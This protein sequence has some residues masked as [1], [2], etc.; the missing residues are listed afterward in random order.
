MGKKKVLL[1]LD[2]LG[3]LPSKQL[4]GKTP[5]EAAKTPNLDYLAMNSRHGYMY[6]L[7]PGISPESD[8]ATLA[9]LGYNPL[10]VYTGR[11]PLEAYGTGM[12]LGRNFLALRANFAT[13]RNGKLADRRVG[14]SL[15]S[16]EAFVLAKEINR[17]VKLLYKFKF[18]PTIQHRGILVIYSNL[19]EH[20]SNTD[21]SYLKKGN[22]SVAVSSLKIKKC[23][24]LSKD[25]K[26]KLA[27]H[28]INSFTSQSHSI[29]DKSKVNIA[30][31][32]RKLLPANYI[33]LR[34]AGNKL[35]R[36]AKKKESWLAIT[37]MPL[38][39]GISKLAGMKVYKVHYP[40]I[41]ARDPYSQSSATLAKTISTAKLAI[42]KN[43]NRYDA[44]YIHI[45]E[46]DIPGHDG[47][48]IEKK[49]MIEIIDRNLASFLK[50][51][52]AALI[53]TADHSTPCILKRHSHHPVPVLIHDKGSDGIPRFTERLS[54]KG[55]LGKLLGKNILQQLY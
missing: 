36:L 30:R 7:K 43:W 49:K 11:G 26:S 18:L 46:T 13:V 32:E 5:L 45:K 55:S 10:K 37:G 35:P 47:N 3:D 41:K 33:L 24:P 16:R 48:P 42:R 12:N 8:T 34:D 39:A 50:E 54:R 14:R 19:S 27:A 9:V 51:I 2:G 4:N 25:K 23:I 40:E 28:V 53:I 17:K 22:I 52:D 20:V 29:L 1:I 6:P 15:T 21:P 44:F 38:E 31:I